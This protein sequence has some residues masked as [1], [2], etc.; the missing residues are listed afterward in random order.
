VTTDDAGASIVAG[1]SLLESMLDRVRRGEPTDDIVGATL[2]H[3][4]V[5]QLLGPPALA[6]AKIDWL[7]V[8]G[9]RVD[10]TLTAGD[11]QWRVVFGCSSS[12][13]TGAAG[14]AAVVDWLDVFERPAHFDGVAGGRAVVV[15]GPSGA[16]KSTLL[17][18]LQ[19]T[20]HGPLVVFDEP[21]HIGTV[22]PEYLIW[23]DRAPGLHRGYLDAIAALA[24]AGNQVAVSAAGHRQADFLDAFADVPML[25]VG[26]T[27]ELDVLL[28]RERRTGRWG[29]IA[30][31]SL[32]VHDDWVYD[33]EFDTTDDPDPAALA[34]QISEHLDGSRRNST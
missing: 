26:L 7:T 4:R 28:H 13:G 10:A 31:G 12:A 1:R 11:E 18:A 29:G 9:A 32:D 15:N 6:E 30:A 22:R 8:N 17:R 25:A 27:C 19:R 23:R 5:I 21:E 16:G 2:D 20:A 3:E 33:L 34:R 14:P 24:R